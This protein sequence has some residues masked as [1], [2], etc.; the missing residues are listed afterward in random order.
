MKSPAGFEHE[1]AHNLTFTGRFVYRDLR[2]IIED[3]SGINVTQALARRAADLRGRQ[4]V[5]SRWTSSRT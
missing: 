3:M 2:R 1:F 5:A 4:S